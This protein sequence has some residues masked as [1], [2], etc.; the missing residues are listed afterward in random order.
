MRSELRALALGLAG[1]LGGATPALAQTPVP[2]FSDSVVVT[3]SA[4]VRSARTCRRR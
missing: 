3:A 4:T 2:G 1:V